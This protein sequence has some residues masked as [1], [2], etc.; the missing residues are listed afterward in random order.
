[1]VVRT[2]RHVS[3]RGVLNGGM[4]RK[5]HLYQ[6]S[7]KWWYVQTGALHCLKGLSTRVQQTSMARLNRYKCMCLNFPS[8]PGSKCMFPSHP[9]RRQTF[10]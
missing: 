5:T 6:G 1:M 8:Y 7:F 3:I 10:F 9:Q 2:E 4:Y